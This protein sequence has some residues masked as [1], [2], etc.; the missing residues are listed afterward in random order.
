[1]LV[2]VKVYSHKMLFSMK[3]LYLLMA[4]T[5]PDV[6]NYLQFLHGTKELS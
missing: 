5:T 4:K 6:N 2:L 3:H 1:M